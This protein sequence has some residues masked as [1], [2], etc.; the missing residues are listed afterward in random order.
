METPQGVHTETTQVG[1]G[2]STVGNYRLL[3]RNG[4]IDE[5][6]RHWEVEDIVLEKV[7]ELIFDL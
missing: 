5:H 6:G 1:Y 3:Q 7:R 2:R 4:M